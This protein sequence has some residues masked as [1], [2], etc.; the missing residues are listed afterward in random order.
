MSST[1]GNI[2]AYYSKEAY[3]GKARWATEHHK[4]MNK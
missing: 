3:E 2:M 4:K 1:G